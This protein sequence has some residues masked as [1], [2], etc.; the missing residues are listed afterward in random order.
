MNKLG[1][2]GTLDAARRHDKMAHIQ[3]IPRYV[4]D[5]RQRTGLYRGYILPPDRLYEAYEAASQDYAVQHAMQYL[6]LL[7]A[8]GDWAIETEDKE[9]QPVAAIVEDALKQ[10]RDF[11]H[12]RRSLAW[13]ALYG[14]MISRKTFKK[15]LLRL[16][17]VGYKLI[18]DVPISLREVDW[19]RLRLE[20]NPANDDRMAWYWTIHSLEVD[21]YL[22]IGDRR[23]GT[24]AP[25]YQ[26]FLW[27]FSSHEEQQAGYGR[28][29]GEVLYTI[30]FIKANLLQYRASIAERFS[31]PWVIGKLSTLSG[32]LD[33]TDLGSG[34]AFQN[35]STVLTEFLDVLE[36]MRSRHVI[37]VDKEL[38]D[39]DIKEVSGSGDRT[40]GEFIAYLDKQITTLILGGTLATQQGDGVGSYAQAKQHASATDAVVIYHRSRLEEVFTRDL[41][42]EFIE[43]NKSTFMALDLPIPESGQ[44]KFKIRDTRE[45]Q[46]G[47]QGQSDSIQRLQFAMQAGIN[48]KKSEVYESL[49]FTMPNEKDADDLLDWSEI[50][51]AAPGG[52]GGG[53][54]FQEEPW[55][56]QDDHGEEKPTA[57]SGDERIVWPESAV[58]MLRSEKNCCSPSEREKP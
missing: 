48:L 7:A 37:A 17:E 27:Y 38:H 20:R 24:K 39:I 1:Y 40:L 32:V 13:G 45:Q 22:I 35:V 29:F 12:G 49:N 31:E 4:Q 44:L 8:G 33:S 9:F 58:H 25:N 23:K 56:L 47:G 19:R 42:G 28:G 15:K 11:M 2:K 18:W 3:H 34:D 14:M 57:G 16:G 43:R 36:K 52:G 53:F 21:Q 46:G 54:P 50:K 5:L 41:V 6:S 30:L 55:D 26:D 10:I 51:P